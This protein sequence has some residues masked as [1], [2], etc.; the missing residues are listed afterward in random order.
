M[1]SIDRTLGVVYTLCMSSKQVDRNK[2][3]H[4]V[5]KEGKTLE[6]VARMFGVTRERVR[7]ICAKLD[8]MERVNGINSYPQTLDRTIDNNTARD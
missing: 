1:S 7:Q 3:I 5:R 2:L 4:I 8:E 6:A